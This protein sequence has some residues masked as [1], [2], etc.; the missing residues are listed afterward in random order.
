MID[1]DIIKIASFNRKDFMNITEVQLL[2][3]PDI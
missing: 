1:N 2:E 3:L